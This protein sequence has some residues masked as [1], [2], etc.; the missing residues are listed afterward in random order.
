MGRSY[1]ITGMPW[2]WACWATWMPAPFRS[3]STIR[4]QPD[5]SI[6]WAIVAYFWVSFSAFWMLILKPAA[7]N[8]FFSSGASL[9]TQRLELSGSGMIAHTVLDLVLFA[10]LL[11]P[12]LADLPLSL[13]SLLPQPANTSAPA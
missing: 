5:V 6:C 13:L 11:L 7:S 10:G 3:V 1:A 2:L 12:L 8:C 9:C 4:L